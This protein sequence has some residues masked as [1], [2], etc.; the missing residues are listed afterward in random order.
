[1]KIFDWYIFKSGADMTFFLK[2]IT[3][4]L[5]TLQYAFGNGGA[6]ALDEMILHKNEGIKKA[7]HAREKEKLSNDLDKIFSE[8]IENQKKE[9]A[10][11]KKMRRKF[12][13]KVDEPQR[14]F[15][16]RGSI[17][18]GYPK[19]EIKEDKKYY[20]ITAELPGILPQNINIQI[21]ENFIVIEGERL[22]EIKKR[23]QK[24]RSTEIN[25][26]E[27]KRSIPLDHKVNPA[28][29]KT[30]NKNGLLIIHVEKI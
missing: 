5:L 26:G 15:T 14:G 23:N 25:Y 10:R 4:A 2:T 28:T 13:P 19:I 18:L 11:L 22:K 8:M 30:E 9:V 1:M 6:T 20:D 3:L 17:S 27:F 12:F 24:I 21:K 29:L 7:K 16:Q